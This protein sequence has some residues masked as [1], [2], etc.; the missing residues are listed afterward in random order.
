MSVAPHAHSYTRAELLD[1]AMNSPRAVATHDRAAWIGLFAECHVVEDPIGSTPHIGGV[2]DSVSGERGR[3]ALGRFF[4]TFIA[5][6]DIV[7]KVDRDVVCDY[8]VV[9]DLTIEIQMAPGVLVST[10]MHLLYELTEERNRLKIQRLAAHW[11]LST[12][13]KQVAKPS[14]SHIKVNNQLGLRM[15]RL[16]GIGGMRGFMRG[17]SSVGDAGKRAVQ[18]FAECLERQDGNALRQLLTPD[19][20]IEFPYGSDPI[21][22]EL[23]LP[24][25]RQLTLTKLLA[26]G[27]T[28]TASFAL[29]N[30]H[31]GVVFFYFNRNTL[32]IRRAVFYWDE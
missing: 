17:L 10:P 9:R 20:R 25:A 27:D 7:F 2:F 15:L 18:R 3:G 26:A 29:N 5:P 13:L 31:R 21:S 11:E 6:N 8:H 16:Q 28:V 32:K 4:D 14:L 22:I 30:Q 19:S 12:M 23:L 24:A 1:T